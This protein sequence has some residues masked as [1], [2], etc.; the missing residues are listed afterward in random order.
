LQP[1]PFSLH[2]VPLISLLGGPTMHD[3][4]GI[5]PLGLPL[6]SRPVMLI[7]RIISLSVA[8]Y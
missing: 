7:S 5:P 1:L 4:L 8:S 3:S 6:L 2:L